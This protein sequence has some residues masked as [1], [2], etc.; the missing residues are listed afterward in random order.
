M[1]AREDNCKKEAR[2]I[3]NIRKPALVPLDVLGASGLERK[4]DP[5]VSG[6]KALH[7]IASR[8]GRGRTRAGV[9]TQFSSARST[10]VQL[11]GILSLFS[12][13]LFLCFI[14]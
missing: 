2:I 3:R 13:L 12:F 9:V 8:C 4:S 14:A 5:K 7:L 1:R 6:K 11:S 10:R